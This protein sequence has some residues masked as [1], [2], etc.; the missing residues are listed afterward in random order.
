MEKQNPVSQFAEFNKMLE[1]IQGT[2]GERILQNL[3]E[4]EAILTDK[5]FNSIP[6]L[7]AHIKNIKELPDIIKVIQELNVKSEEYGNNID[8]GISQ[9]NNALKK[10]NDDAIKQML[11][12][13]KIAVLNTTNVDEISKEFKATLNAEYTAVINNFKYETNKTLEELRVKTKQVSANANTEIT[14]EVSNA[15]KYNI[16]EELNQTITA[17][18]TAAT[19]LFK[20]NMQ[21]ALNEFRREAAQ[22][23]TET[24]KNVLVGDIKKR[25]KLKAALTYLLYTCVGAGIG[26]AGVIYFNLFN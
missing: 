26:G 14:K 10:V 6:E 23:A 20:N 8:S 18:T 7:V 9:L 11:K 3:F 1:T 16:K 5:G 25:S 17:A 22:V 4:L 24:A 19:A 15:I 2:N 12:S 21:R 13:F